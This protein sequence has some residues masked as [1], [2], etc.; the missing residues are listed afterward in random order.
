MRSSAA[1]AALKTDALS[2]VSKPA[3]MN[4]DTANTTSVAALPRAAHRIFTPK[5]KAL[6]SRISTTVAP[7]A[8]AG[9][10]LA[11]RYGARVCTYCVNVSKFPQKTWLVPGFPH[12]PNRS[13]RA[14]RN[15]A[16]SAALAKIVAADQILL[17]C[18][19]RVRSV[20]VTSAML[21]PSSFFWQR[22]PD[23]HG[24]PRAA[25]RSS[26]SDSFSGLDL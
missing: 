10:S 12:N 14:D 15:A 8:T 23:L 19:I 21:L 9:T 1:A 6:L 2:G 22:A 3:K 16:A 18:D 13:A 7:Q 4:I 25:K 20:R 5:S 24:T 26:L 11:D 17:S